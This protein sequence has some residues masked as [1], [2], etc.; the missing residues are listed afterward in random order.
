MAAFFYSTVDNFLATE[1]SQILC[2]LN[3]R[4]KDSVSVIRIPTFLSW[5]RTIHTL[6]QALKLLEADFPNV[7]A[8]GLLL[9][10]EIPRR[11]RRIDAV[12]L[13]G[14]LVLVLEFKTGESDSEASACR[15]AEHYA[16]EL[17]DFHQESRN[18]ILVPIAVCRSAA[19]FRQQVLEVNQ[20]LVRAVMIAQDDSLATAFRCALIENPGTIIQPQVA[21]KNWNESNYEPIPNIVEAAQIIYAG[22]SVRELSHAHTDAHNLTETTD[23]LVATVELAQKECQKVICFVTGVPGAGKTLAGLNAVHSPKLMRD[24]RPA[25][26]FLSGNIPLVK[27]ITEALARDHHARTGAA[28]GESRRRIGTFIQGVHGFLKEYRAGDKIPPENVV[29]FD[30]AQRAWDATK[31]R[32]QFLQRATSTEREALSGLNSE[33]AMMIGIMDRVPSWAVIIALVGGGQ[34]IHDGEA[35]LAE[36]GRV[37]CEDFPHWHIVASPESINGGASLAGSRLFQDGQK[38]DVIIKAETSLHLPVSARSF[39]AGA[40]ASWVNAVINGQPSEA[41][42]IAGGCSRFPIVLTRSLERVRAWL[43]RSTRGLRRS[44]LLASSGALR[45][46]AHGLEVSPGFRR[47]I[48]LEEWFLAPP[49]DVRSSNV[50]EVALTEFECQ[51]LELDWVGVCWGGDFTRSGNE[52][53]FQRFTGSAWQQ[54][55]KPVNQEFIRNKYRVLLTRAREGLAIWVPLGDPSDE[56]RPSGRL[57]DTAD[58]LKACGAI[59]IDSR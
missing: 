5:E 53:C 36:W 4:A 49:E 21:V 7:G 42:K 3:L 27:V 23:M 28:L 31:V 33:P 59:S 17:R 11:G 56:T 55:R 12:L 9:E 43:R 13:A 16:L 45:L 38:R 46:R 44:G 32:K 20:D 34:E 15:Q 22:Q 29:I 26:A 52:W 37:L 2:E 57:D 40:V 6:K 58:Y 25:G 24:G 41:A 50:L 8:W 10:Y 18:K 54:V 19:G 30:E 51:G 47:G 48:S 14:A 35:G 1:S 39:R